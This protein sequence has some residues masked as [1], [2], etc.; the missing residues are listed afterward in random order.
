MLCGAPTGTTFDQVSID[1]YK[2]MA[3]TETVGRAV[4]RRASIFKLAWELLFVNRQIKSLLTNLE[5][6]QIP[7]TEKLPNAISRLRE[8]HSVLNMVLELAN[9]MNHPLVNNSFQTLR[10]LNMELRDIIE[11]FEVSLDSSTQA[12][13]MQ[14][15]YHEFCGE[16]RE[17]AEGAFAAGLSQPRK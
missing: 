15:F 9:N 14:S 16:L 6:K 13:Q 1:Y 7:S 17:V 8:L 2:A 10:K 3:T 12:K 4:E 11:R 5:S